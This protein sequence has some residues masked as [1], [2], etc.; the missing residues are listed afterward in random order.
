MYTVLIEVMPESVPGSVRDQISDLGPVRHGSEH[1]VVEMPWLLDVGLVLLEFEED[2]LYTSSVHHHLM[3]TVEGPLILFED[4]IVSVW[5]PHPSVVHPY[6]STNSVWGLIRAPTAFRILSPLKSLG[7]SHGHPPSLKVRDTKHL[8]P[9]PDY[10]TRTRHGEL[11]EK[12]V[13]YTSLER[14]PYSKTPVATPG[15]PL[16][17]S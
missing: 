14:R 1:V 8:W 3:A 11:P 6:D 17:R 10:P 2:R 15:S 12:I 9:D 4:S 16:Q 5:D 13:A 7:H